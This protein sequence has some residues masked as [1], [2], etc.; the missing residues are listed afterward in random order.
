MRTPPERHFNLL[1]AETRF[2]LQTQRGTWEECW[3]WEGSIASHGYGK[4]IVARVNGTN[5]PD[6]AHRFSYE[7]FFGEIAEGFHIDHL[8]RN[9]LCVNPNHLETVTPAENS[10][11]AAEDRTHCRHGHVYT[12]QSYYRNRDGYRICL[13]CDR[14]RYLRKKARQPANDDLALTLL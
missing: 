11:R 3:I 7:I 5:Q 9:R 2:W 14:V 8:C 1:S 12:E 6:L 4:L 10:R 13:I